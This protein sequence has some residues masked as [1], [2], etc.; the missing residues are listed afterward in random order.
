MAGIYLH[1][2]WCRKVCIYCDFHFSVSMGNKN[3][4]LGCM[5]GELELQKDYLG[6]ESIETIY[7]GGG[8][9]SVLSIKEIDSVIQKINSLFNIAKNAE[10]SLEA[11]PDDLSMVYLKDLNKLGINRLSIGIQSFSDEDLKWMNRRHDSKQAFECIEN[12]RQAGFENISIDLIYGLPYMGIRTWA[13]NLDIAFKSKVQH[14]SAYHLTLENKTV[15]AHK[16]KK[17]QMKEPDETR[18]LEQFEFLVDTAEREGFEHY[19]I[20]NFCLPGFY[21]RHNTAYW[22]LKPYLGIGPSANS[23]NGNTRQWNIRSNSGYIKNIKE[24]IIPFELEDL[25]VNRKYN[26]YILTSLRTMWGIDTLKIERDHGSV[27]LEYFLSEAALFLDEGKLERCRNRVRLS[28]SGKFF[29]DGI[30]SQLFFVDN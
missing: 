4:L 23:Y 26:E 21:S 7:F 18:G 10:I 30:I 16:I 8:T 19:E 5:I 14:L 25:D 2:P 17:G 13:N 29:A 12:S 28:R 11:N 1:I 24:G 9:P 22:S 20:S 3:E 15:Y 6:K 27:F